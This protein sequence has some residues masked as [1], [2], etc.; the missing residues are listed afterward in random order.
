MTMEDLETETPAPPKTVAAWWRPV[1][2]VAAVL[3]L[4][5]FVLWMVTGLPGELSEAEKREIRICEM[6]KAIG[7]ASVYEAEVLCSRDGWQR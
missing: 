6:S 3:A 5:L 1:A 2:I 4:L 7:G